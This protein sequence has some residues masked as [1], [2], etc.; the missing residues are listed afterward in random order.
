M[1]DSSGSNYSSDDIDSGSSYDF[2]GELLNKKYIPVYKL[3][4]GSFATVWLSLNMTSNKFYAI[5]VQNANDYDAG[6][7]EMD[8]L[9]KFTKDKSPFMNTMIEHFEHDAEGDIYVCMVFELMAGSVFDIMQ[10]GKLSKGLPLSSVKKIV[11]VLVNGLHTL[12]T[13]YDTLYSDVKPDNILIKGMNNKVKKIITLIQSNKQFSEK[14]SKIKTTKNPNKLLSSLKKILYDIN[15]KNITD[16]YNNEHNGRD[17][18]LVFVDDQYVDSK[19]IK[20]ILSDFGTCKPAKYEKHD[21]QTRYYR[22]PEMILEYNFNVNCDMWSVGCVIYE[23]LTGD[24]LFD[25]DKTAKLSRDRYHLYDMVSV[26]GPVPQEL[27]EKSKKRNV[28]FRHNSLL[29]GVDNIDYELLHVKLCRELNGRADINPTELCLTLDL[30]YKLLNYDPFKR[31]SP[32][33]C[34]EHAWFNGMK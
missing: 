32:Q 12:N 30:L 27:I 28:F 16:E 29:K 10:V 3:G 18:N 24:F 8:Y 25:P 11:H 6:L 34:L 2:I 7:L 15:I 4:Y 5:K 21:L 13:K 33:K 31:L 20:P 1:S 22:A 19:N 17:D 23:L 9:K 14:I 26:L